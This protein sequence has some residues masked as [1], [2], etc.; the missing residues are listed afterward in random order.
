MTITKIYEISSEWRA[1]ASLSSIFQLTNSKFKPTAEWERYCQT[2]EM[3]VNLFSIAIDNNYFIKSKAFIFVLFLLQIINKLLIIIYE[4]ST[5]NTGCVYM[6]AF[7][8]DREFGNRIPVA[9]Q[10]QR[11]NINPALSRTRQLFDWQSQKYIPAKV[12]EFL[13]QYV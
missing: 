8:V 2:Y 6:A 10:T 7:C 3:H 5:G 12:L 4:F 11:S 13:N 1:T 9:T